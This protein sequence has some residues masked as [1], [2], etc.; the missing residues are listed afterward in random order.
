MAGTK[1]SPHGNKQERQ[2]EQIEQ[3]YEQRGVPQRE[4]ER[5]AWSTVNKMA[6]ANKPAGSHD[7]GTINDATAGN[8]GVSAER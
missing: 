7:G 4:A 3:G 5:R 6:K 2:A 8:G 1:K